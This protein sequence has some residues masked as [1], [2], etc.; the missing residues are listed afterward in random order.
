MP[1][2]IKKICPELELEATIKS[3][4]AEFG[5]VYIMKR[6]TLTGYSLY[7]YK[8]AELYLPREPKKRKPYKQRVATTRPRGSYSK[9]IKLDDVLKILSDV[10]GE[11]ETLKRIVSKL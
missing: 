9:K 11:S 1:Y 10:L 2:L 6:K 3:I 4:N 8:K 5:D 7:A